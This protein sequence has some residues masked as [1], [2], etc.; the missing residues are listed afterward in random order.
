VA[1]VKQ[2]RGANEIT[3]AEPR[4]M[5]RPSCGWPRRPKPATTLPAW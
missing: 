4:S 2:T 5:R 1:T 3:K